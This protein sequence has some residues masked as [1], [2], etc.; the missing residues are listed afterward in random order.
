VWSFTGTPS[1]FWEFQS[2]LGGPLSRPGWD[3]LTAAQQAPAHAE[4]ERLHAPYQVG[5]Q[6][7]IPVVVNLATVLG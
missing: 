2:A 4:A 5:D 7:N 6:L 3:T 1:R